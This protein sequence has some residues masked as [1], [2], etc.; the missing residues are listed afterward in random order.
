[1]YNR[2]MGVE[3]GLALVRQVSCLSLDC[4]KYGLPSVQMRSDRSRASAVLL[5]MPRKTD[6]QTE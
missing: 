2:K 4:S 5:S 6:S 3:Q 1:M